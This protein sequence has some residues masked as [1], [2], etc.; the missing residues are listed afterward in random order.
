MDDKVITVYLSQQH[1]IPLEVDLFCRTGEILAILGPSGSGKTTI[2]RC[3]AGLY[4]PKNGKISANGDCWFDSRARINRAVQKRQTGFV[5]QHYALFRHLSAL[6]NICVPLS[7]L[8]KADQTNI[9][10]K[11][12]TRVNMQ[13]LGQRYPHQLSG[14]QQQ[15]IA[16]ARALAREPKVLLL[17]E[18]F[19]AVDQ[20]TR[21]KLVRE[22]VQLRAKVKIPI[23]HV[24]HDLT[25][26]RRIADRICIIHHG[27]ILQIDVPQKIMAQPVNKQVAHLVGHYNVFSASVERHDPEK[28][29][30]YIN[31]LNYS[32]ETPHRPELAV[33]EQ[34]DWVIPAENLILHRRNRPSKG[35]RENPV[36][37]EICEYIPLG[38]NTSVLMTVKG[39]DQI[40]SMS[41]PTHVAKRNG[42]K[43]G[44]EICV[45]LLSD[46]IHIMNSP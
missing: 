3:I 30:S 46:G 19:S 1:P 41:V 29:K 37:G 17:D 12:L 31:W 20:Q 26:A 23:I 40:L 11:M 34:V 44:I 7:H 4:T 36:A 5:F 18:P 39:S 32:L 10:E 25:E 33:G 27:K 16:L 6:Q 28:Q 8:Q 15:R 43:T 14:G 24:T 21:H 13:G 42:L 9:A 2:L 45:S 35:E 38:E 22:L